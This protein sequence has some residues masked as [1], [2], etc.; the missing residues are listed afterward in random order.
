MVIIPN[1]EYAIKLENL[2]PNKEYEVLSKD[3][4]NNYY[5]T[6]DDGRIRPHAEKYFSIKNK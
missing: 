1:I 2:T 4:G 6:A 3:R 5:I